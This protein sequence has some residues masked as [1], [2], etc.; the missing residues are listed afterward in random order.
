MAFLA[1]VLASVGQIA[2][3]G[4]TLLSAAGAIQQGRE[5]KARYEY[6]Q[7]VQTAAADEAQAASQRDALEQRRQGNFLL[8]QQRAALAGSGGDMTDPSV[9][10]LMGDTNEKVQLAVDT[11]AYKGDQQAKG[12]NDA[13]KVAGVNAKSAMQAARLNAL[14][15]IFEGVSSMYSRFGQP[16]KKPTTS[17]GVQLPYG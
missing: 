10:K 3:I 11:E 7:K 12:Y 13:A 8:S 4:G 2:A 9:I 17:S 15:S 1:P 16:Q 5:Q 6:E 14:G